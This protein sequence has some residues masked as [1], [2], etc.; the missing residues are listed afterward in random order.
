MRLPRLASISTGRS[1]TDAFGGYNHNLRIGDGEWFDMK[2]MTSD[3]LP[4]MSPRGARGKW[5]S[6]VG[7]NGI[8]V[9]NGLCYVQG[10]QFILPSGEE[11]DLDLT[12]TEKSLV[13]MGAYVIIFPDKKWVNTVTGENGLLE[14]TIDN[15]YVTHCTADGRRYNSD[16]AW[17]KPAEPV[18]GQCWVDRQA[19]PPVFYKWSAPESKWVPEKSYIHITGENFAWREGNFR[20][21]DVYVSEEILYEYNDEEEQVFVYLPENPEIV[22]VKK[23]GE[24]EN[25]QL[26]VFEGIV[27]HRMEGKPVQSTYLSETVLQ[28]KI[29]DMDIVIESGNRLWGCKYGDSEDGFLNEIYASK[30]GDFRNWYSFKKGISTDSYAVS[31]GEGGPFTGAINYGGRPIFFKETCMVEVYGAYPAQYQVVTTPCIGVQKGSG[32][33]VAVVGDQLFYKGKDGVYSFDGAMPVRISG[34]LG[35]EQYDSA[36]GGNLRSKYYIS[37]RRNDGQWELLVYDAAK[38]LW[39]KEDDLQVHAFYNNDDDLFAVTEND[40]KVL[41]MRGS[42][43]PDDQPVEWMVQSGEIGL[44]LPDAKYVTRLTVRM[45]LEEGSEATFLVQYDFEEEWIHL[46]TIPGTSLRSFDIP[47]RPKRCDHMK[48]RIEGVGGAKIYSIT[49]TIEQGSDVM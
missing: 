26:P 8:V 31:I 17:T 44:S 5:K 36:V 28:R 27:V 15:I 3:Y 19:V 2:N 46:C 30:L 16:I 14:D 25:L 13:P 38:A 43:D 7:I 32:K 45:S 18:D 1:V 10:G 6:K 49:K 21:G 47:I 42:V 29:P 37:M 41:T 4:V 35:A 9:N 24:D 48:L 33:S 34:P 39:H 11:V 20:V 23:H 22:Y 40:T 12:D